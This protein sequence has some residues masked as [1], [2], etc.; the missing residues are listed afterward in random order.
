MLCSFHRLGL[1]AVLFGLAAC[2]KNADS[3]EQPPAPAVGPALYRVT[4]EATWSASTHANFPAGA[5]FSSVIGASH[6]AD[7]LLFRPGQL[8][9]TGIKNMAERGNNTALRTEIMALQSSGAAFRVLEGRVISSP[10]T[11]ADTIRL[12]AAH[13]RLSLV[14]MIA[15][16]PDWFVALEDENLLDANGQWVTQRRVPARAYDAGTDSGPTFT[17]PDQATLPA[18]VVAPLL[19]PPAAGPAPDGPPLGTWLL[20]RVN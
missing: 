9:S 18:G 2:S 11:V 1:W 14:T 16:S 17:A 8:A 5:H 20:E 7:G 4:F 15:P 3:E 13:P 19:L 12:D 6:R 10:G